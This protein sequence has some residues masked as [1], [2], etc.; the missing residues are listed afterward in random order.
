MCVGG[1]KADVKVKTEQIKMDTKMGTDIEEPQ[2]YY[3]TKIILDRL[4]KT[5]DELKE[6]KE[7]MDRILKELL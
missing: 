5:E 2:L 7:K 4:K 1:E 6:L 3:C